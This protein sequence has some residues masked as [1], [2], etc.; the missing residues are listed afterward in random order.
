MSRSSEGFV[1]SNVDRGEL[2]VVHARESK[3]VS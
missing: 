2:C 3:E 1:D